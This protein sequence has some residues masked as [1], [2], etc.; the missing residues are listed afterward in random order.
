MESG[1]QAGQEEGE[2]EGLL[3]ERDSV[4][5]KQKSLTQQLSQ[6]GWRLPGFVNIYVYSICATKHGLHAQ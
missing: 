1:Q 6:A 5:S 4:R 3:A 2:A